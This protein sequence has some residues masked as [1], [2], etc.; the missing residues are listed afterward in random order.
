MSEELVKKLKQQGFTLEN[1]FL[2]INLKEI[3]KQIFGNFKIFRKR[4]LRNF[5]MVLFL[6]IF[7]KFLEASEALKKLLNTF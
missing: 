1:V 5:S 3:F 7:T 4:F 2:T 6:R